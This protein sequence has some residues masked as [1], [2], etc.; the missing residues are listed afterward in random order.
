MREENL[1]IASQVGNS[2]R[3]VKLDQN[4]VGRLSRMDALQGQALAKAGV[5][6]QQLTGQRID[7]A[8]NQIDAGDYGRCLDCD[9]PIASARL[10][11]DPIAQYCIDCASKRER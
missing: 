11:I 6:R 3:T 7:V 8:L 4:S 9:D 2:A 1:N 10:E 5:N